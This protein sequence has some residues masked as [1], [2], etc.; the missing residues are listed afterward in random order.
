MI[1]YN[2][3]VPETYYVLHWTGDE[4][5]VSDI[6]TDQSFTFKSDGSLSVLCDEHCY[7]CRKGQYLLL[8]KY[9]DVD[10]YCPVSV[11]NNLDSLVLANE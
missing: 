7:K 1:K 9:S 2:L 4:N 6:L 5:E 8:C 11:L 3:K 10:C